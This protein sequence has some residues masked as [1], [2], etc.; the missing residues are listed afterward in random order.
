MLE[1]RVVPKTLRNVSVQMHP[2]LLHLWCVRKAHPSLAPV[3]PGYVS[4]APFHSVHGFAAVPWASSSWNPCSAPGNGWDLR[5][6]M[7]SGPAASCPTR[8]GSELF[9]AA[10]SAPGPQQKGKCQSRMLE[11]IKEQRQM[12]Q[13][14]ETLRAGYEQQQGYP[15]IQTGQS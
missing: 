1:R 7:I 8:A 2:Y 3:S 12:R 9:A 15:A 5:T 4:E 11:Q 14:R 10:L 13:K 6:V